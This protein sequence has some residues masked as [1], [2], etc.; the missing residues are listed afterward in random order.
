MV[1]WAGN[2]TRIGPQPAPAT[3][4]PV[5]QSNSPLKRSDASSVCLIVCWMLR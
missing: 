4:V 1:A 5:A 3:E 2:E